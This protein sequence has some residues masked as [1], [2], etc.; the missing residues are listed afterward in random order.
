MIIDLSFW[1]GF[2][3]DTP[4]VGDINNDGKDDIA[5]VHN[6]AWC[7]SRDGNTIPEYCFWYGYPGDTPLI[8]DINQDGKDDIAFVHNGAWYVDGLDDIARFK[9][10]AWYIDTNFDLT[11]DISVWYGYPEDTPVG[12]GEF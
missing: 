1:Y 9:D 11:P 4:V 3:G 2:P 12:G 7:V 6:G 10:G 8:G 5:F